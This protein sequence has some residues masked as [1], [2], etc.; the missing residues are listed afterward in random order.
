[1]AVVGI[2]ADQS[3]MWSDSAGIDLRSLL[4]WEVRFTLQAATPLRSVFLFRVRV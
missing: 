1:M 2:R 4:Q 3:D